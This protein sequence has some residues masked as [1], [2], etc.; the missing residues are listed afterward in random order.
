MSEE[1]HFSPFVVGVKHH[2]NPHILHFFF[3]NSLKSTDFASFGFCFGQVRIIYITQTDFASC[4]V[5]F[6]GLKIHNSL[7]YS[8]ELQ[9]CL[10]LMRIISGTDGIGKLPEQR[11][12]LYKTIR[13]A[14]KELN[15]KIMIFPYVSS[16]IS[17][18]YM[19]KEHF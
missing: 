13:I 11:F 2:P 7:L 15:L 6:S 18:F 3:E 4:S 8:G 10:N 1:G 12:Y 19:N 17:N 9:I 16:L 5:S 14:P